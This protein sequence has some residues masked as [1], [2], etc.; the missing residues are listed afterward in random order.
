MTGAAFGKRRFDRVGGPAPGRGA[1][2]PGPASAAPDA[3]PPAFLTAAAARLGPE[4]ATKPAPVATLGLL[5]VLALIFAGEVS[6][7]LDRGSTLAFNTLSLRAFG[8][9]GLALVR[10]G[11]WWRLFT[12]PM[13]HA[14]AL[15][16]VGN[17]VALILAGFLLERLVGWGWFLAV[18]FASALAGDFVSLQNHDPQMMSVGASGGIMGLLSATVVCSFHGGAKGQQGRMRF[19][20]LR[21][22][23]P[24][25]LPLS[26]DSSA[27]GLTIDYSDHAGGAI[28]GAAMGLLINGVWPQGEPRPVMK[29]LAETFALACV[30]VTT[31]A[32]LMVAIHFPAYQTMAATLAPDSEIP[33]DT[34]RAIE[35][36]QDLV[37]R[38]PQDPRAHLFRALSYDRAGM[39]GAAEDELQTGLSETPQLDVLGL[40]LKNFTRLELVRVLIEEGR[41]P[42]AKAAAQPICD[43]RFSDAK[44]NGLVYKI[45]TWQPR[46]GGG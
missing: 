24:A 46:P 36:G 45:C 38:F 31:V 33:R 29:P 30:A 8:G 3:S 14:N 35:A 19:L 7:A 37:N 32:F 10:Q 12:A 39:H 26:G 34:D 44:L 13:L 42:D 16:L 41:I 25:L 4:R 28:A 15:H 17:S 40:Q 43:Y 22:M 21:F 23:I 5:I 6:Q 27:H 20:A 18:F 11:E 1:T 2:T 9:D